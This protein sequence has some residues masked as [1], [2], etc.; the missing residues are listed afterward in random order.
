M[1]LE[2]AINGWNT[3]KWGDYRVLRPDE[4]GWSERPESLETGPGAML[5]FDLETY[6]GLDPW[7]P[8]ARI[9]MAVISDKPG[10]AWVIQLPPDSSIPEWLDVLMR[11]PEVVKCGSNIKFDLKWMQRFG[12]EVENMW[13][14][15]TAEHVIDETDPLKDLKSLTFRYLPRLAD[16][17]RGHRSL[18]AKRGGWEY[19]DDDEQYDY[20]GADGEASVAA[21]IGQ[22]HV[23]D[24][25]GLR[26]PHE[27]IKDLYP[28]LGNMES[29]GVCVSRS[30]NRRLDGRFEE[31]LDALRDKICDQLGPI[32]PNSPKQLVDALY[33]HVPGI[34]LVLKK[35]HATRQLSGTYYRLPDDEDDQ[36]YSTQK[37][38][39]ER[40]SHKH[41][42]IEEILTFRRLQKLH[43]TYVVGMF[44]KHICPHPDNLDYVHTS[45]R[46]DVVETYRLSSQSPNN[47]NL[48]KKPD[49]DDDHPIPP[50][51]NVKRQYISRFDGG[52]ITEG[53]LGQAEVRVA[54]WMSGDT[55]MTE[56][57]MSGEDLHYTMA[58]TVYGKPREEITPLERTQIK[59]TT[60]LVLYGGGARTLGAQ[61][62]IPKS[63]A[64]AIIDQYFSTFSELDDCIKRAHSRVQRDLYLESPFGFRRRF[65]KP[66]DWNTWPGWRIQRQ[67]W[68]FMIQNT[69]ACIAYVA[70][71]DCD[72]A[73]RAAQLRSRMVLQ[74]HDSIVVDT[75][76]GEEEAVAA[77]LRRSL[78]SPDLKRYGVDFDMPLVSDIENGPS[79][80]EVVA[81]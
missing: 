49:I 11:D 65:I 6:P 74:V 55:K 35:H 36:D 7:H 8:D 26:R 46:T 38:I 10:R 23:I 47:Q 58:S 3:T 14:T 54:A 5:G 44:D 13:D 18:V 43:G 52:T 16:Y 19:V 30:E 2:A 40:E 27:L 73:L 80:G 25:T 33:N 64:G 67:A 70:M 51:L 37:A 9:R 45:Y 17:S 32:N 81:V 59:R 34:D 20:A 21:A 53:D 41:G 63:A 15:S 4:P 60:F 68:N 75:Y 42:V 1:D 29:R 57:I 12:H 72:R 56:A 28:V 61:L 66:H 22:Q 77:L 39:L 31:Q 71:I 79:W 62:G 24:A 50:D 48:P 76:P 78:T 69:A